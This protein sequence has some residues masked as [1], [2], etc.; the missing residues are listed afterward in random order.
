MKLQVEFENCEIVWGSETEE[1]LPVDG[2]GIL[3]AVGGFLPPTSVGR[4]LFHRALLHC[5]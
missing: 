4:T 1:I 2:W 3:S 5:I